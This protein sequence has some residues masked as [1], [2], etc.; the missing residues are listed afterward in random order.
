MLEIILSKIVEAAIEKSTESFINK[1]FERRA[2]SNTK[3]SLSSELPNYLAA[4]YA[5]CET[6]KTLINRNDPVNLTDCFVAPD[7]KLMTEV[8]SS[9]D[10][11]QKIEDSGG[12]VVITGLAGKWEIC[13]FEVFI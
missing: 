9:S 5:K 7:F 13:F 12:K 3:L 11:F 1:I 10:F 4:N 2:K 8:V 6:L